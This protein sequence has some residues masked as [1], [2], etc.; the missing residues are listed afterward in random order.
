MSDSDDGLSMFQTSVPVML[1]DDSDV[2][3]ADDSDDSDESDDAGASRAKTK[4]LELDDSDD[5]SAGSD[6]S[7]ASDDEPA[8]VEPSSKRQRTDSGGPPRMNHRPQRGSKEKSAGPSA[9]GKRRKSMK[10]ASK[11]K[12]ASLL[13]DDDDDDDDFGG[14][15]GGGGSAAGSY[16]AV[17]QASLDAINA[18]KSANINFL[19]DVAATRDKLILAIIKDG[20]KKKQYMC[21]ADDPLSTAIEPFREYLLSKNKMKP[22]Q[23]LTLHFNGGEPLDPERTSEV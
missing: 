2:S 16:N 22:E 1:D 11:S 9:T 13:S 10:A 19:A 12:S 23:K 20:G 3:N 21:Y 6:A 17:V 7:D 5:N 14:G 18:T 15:G 4:P 8:V